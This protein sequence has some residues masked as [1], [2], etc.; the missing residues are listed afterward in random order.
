MNYPNLATVVKKNKPSQPDHMAHI[1]NELP[2]AAVYFSNPDLYGAPPLPPVNSVK[3]PPS[4]VYTSDIYPK[5][6][7][8][9]NRAGQKLISTRLG[10]MGN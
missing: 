4:Y 1:S 7:L 8:S 2:G 3:Q 10:S 5:K 6:N 9:S